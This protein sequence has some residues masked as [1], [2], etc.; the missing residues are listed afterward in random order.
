M[1]DICYASCG[2]R[3]F[4]T[5]RL[6]DKIREVIH[7]CLDTERP[8]AKEPSIIEQFLCGITYLEVSLS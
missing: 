5:S 8:Q 2:E 1:A 3:F 7:F 4:V 6:T